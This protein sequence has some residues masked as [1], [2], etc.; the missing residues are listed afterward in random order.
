MSAHHVNPPA[1]E[2]PPDLEALR[3]QIHQRIDEIIAYGLQDPGP[4]SF[5]DFEKTL[6]L[7]L[8]SLGCLLIQL[9]LQAR[10]ARLDLTTWTQ[11]RG[12]CLSEKNAERKLKTSCGEVTY[13]RAYLVPRSGGGSAVHPLDVALGLT[14]DGFSPLVI[15]WFCRLAT[16]VSFHVASGFGEMFL[17]SAPSSS[18]IKKWGLGRPSAS[19]AKAPCLGATATCWS[20][21]STARRFPPPRTKRWGGAERRGHGAKTAAR[22]SGI[23]V[24]RG[25]NVAVGRSGGTRVTR[26]RTAA[27]RR[28]W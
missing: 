2:C 14:R 8:Q 11:A 1:T 27:A 9:F 22:V 5:L 12:Y 10:H 26:A 6:L 13:Q 18:A 4:T 24:V 28:W 7:L 19:S 23:A 16:R 21:R 17:G 20:S 25:G 15:G 3:Q